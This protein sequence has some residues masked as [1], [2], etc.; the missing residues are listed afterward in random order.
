MSDARSPADSGRSKGELDGTA[1]VAGEGDA[2]PASGGAK[3]ARA[4]I[5]GQLKPRKARSSRC[6]RCATGFLLCLPPLLCSCVFLPC[7]SYS[8]WY[9]DEL[10]AVLRNEDARGVTSWSV[11]FTNDFWG[12]PLVAAHSHKSYR[13]F[14]VLSFVLQFRLLG[15]DLFR[16]QP[17]R[18]FNAAL[19]A[20]NA[21]L[22]LALLRHRGLGLSRKWS[23]AA[24]CIFALHPVH[25]ENIVYL[26]GR[27][28]VMATTGFLLALLAYVEARCCPQGSS[29]SGKFRRAGL[30]SSMMLLLLCTGIAAASGLCKESGFTLLV[31]LAGLELMTRQAH[32]RRSLMLA[33]AT[34][35]S[36]A[37]VGY[38]RVQF[39]SGT[40][41]PF[42]YVDTP[43]QYAED[44]A[45]RVWSYLYQHAFYMKLMLLPGH[46]SW[47]Y[48]F[49]ALP[50]LRAT[51]RDPRAL[52][53][54][55]CYLGIAALA[56]WSLSG[57]GLRIQLLGLLQIIVPF[58]PASNLFFTVGTTI[59]ERLLYTST[60][61]GAI[62]MAAVGQRL[63]LLG[64]A[65]SFRS[66]GGAAVR[67]RKLWPSFMCLALLVAY[68][69]K[70][71]E[72]VWQWRSS[73]ALYAADAA[74]WPTSVKTQHQLGTVYHTQGRHEDAL[75]HYK[76]SQAV[77]DDNALTDY[78]IAQ[79]YIETGKYEDA[80][81][82]FEKIMKGHMVG[83]S[84]FNVFGLYVDHGFTL[85]MLRRF[86]EAIPL[87][88]QGL[89]LNLDVPYGLNALGYAYAYTDQLQP[90][91]DAFGQGLEY[92]PD[93][94]VLWSNIGAVLMIGG[95][96]QQAAQ[97]VERAL[98]MEPENP[99]VV[100]NAMLLKRAAE[101]GS[102]IDALP[103]LELF[104]SR[105]P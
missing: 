67:K 56:S 25:T 79:I 83:F 94:P 52:A 50:L 31:V 104:F 24:A 2:Q 92:D 7:L 81:R 71:G 12:T 1:A 23:C 33:L 17:L 75:R 57:R 21:L 47:D 4:A 96:L 6:R 45:V 64:L 98:M 27:A 77:L 78:V 40:S 29:S 87:L 8:E 97:A 62:V 9:I 35:A 105:V 46:L 66:S 95:Q 39:T 15:G 73:E 19:H 20:L 99:I 51:W 74:A 61:G 43:I 63:E 18:A 91:M 16:P 54:I 60:L 103:R 30:L 10:F 59:G 38:A 3:A 70:C 65:G 11:L 32:M 34:L 41:A 72:R 80:L 5:P 101:G 89:N 49:D 44:R 86:Q 55:C 84:R 93:N 100:H 76:A 48:S 53:V 88:L 58:V 36:F 22:L 69:W 42:G 85:V 13:P 102:M 82:Q 90:A 14:S 26:V 28:D 68:G 37:A